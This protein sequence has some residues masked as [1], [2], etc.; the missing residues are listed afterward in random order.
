MK[1]RLL[2]WAFRRPAAAGSCCGGETCGMTMSEDDQSHRD[3][4]QYGSKT[5]EQIRDWR[6]PPEATP[7]F[8]VVLR[9]LMID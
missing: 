9:G 4:Q 2:C 8:D 3:K 5:P 1:P 7:E 6:I